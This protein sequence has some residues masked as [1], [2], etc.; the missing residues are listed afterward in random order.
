M[1]RNFWIGVLGSALV[2]SLAWGYS[3]YRQAENYRNI[4]ENQYQRSL[5]DFASHL[6]QLETDLAKGRVAATSSQKVLHLSQA[7]SISQS[8]MKDLAQLP[9]EEAGLSYVGEFLN[10]AGDFSRALAYRVSVGN[11]LTSEEEKTLADVHERL[12]T[13]NQNIQDL[14]TRVDTE[15]LAWVNEAPTWQHRLA[16]WKTQQAEAAAESS[17]GP[18]SSVRSGLDQLNASLQKLPPF[19]YVGEF[20]SRSV[21]EPLGLPSQEVN[22]DK[23]LEVARDFLNKVG[24]SEVNPEFVGV[25]QGALGGYQWKQGD[26]FMTVSK[27]GGVVTLFR[28]PRELQ[29]RT[30]TPDQAKAKV[31]ETL[32][33]LGWN[34]VLSSTEDYGGY[35]QLEYVQ[36]SEGVRNYPDKVRLTVTLDNGQISGYDSTPYWAYHQKRTFTKKLTLDQARTKLRTGF[37]V[38]ETRMAVIPVIGNREVMAY[39]FRGNYQGEDYLVYINAV[40]GIEERIQRIITTPRGEY[41]Q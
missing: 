14:V 3:E 1:R 26:I 38:K 36:D 41:L 8:A 7:S 30:L 33:A 18:A 39:E 20:E 17:D 29:E 35:L 11:N 37:Q 19:S 34:L 4:T 10:R 27:R 25:T 21:K 31:A 9:A 23:A 32:K 24:Y 40:N 16:F 6:D 15:N 5:R 13:V 2:L 12:L 28:D 22:K